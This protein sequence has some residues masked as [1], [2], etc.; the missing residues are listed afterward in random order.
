MTQE[1]HVH[2][3]TWSQKRISDDQKF[4]SDN[5]LYMLMRDRL[6]N[7]GK[8]NLGEIRKISN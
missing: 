8:I 2:E 4:L 3:G 7:K 6:K 5:G 1:D